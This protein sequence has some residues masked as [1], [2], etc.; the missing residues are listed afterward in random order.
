MLRAP[1]REFAVLFDLRAQD[2][3]DTAGYSRFDL[4]A[5]LGFQERIVGPFGD[6]SE[7]FENTDHRPIIERDVAMVTVAY[8]IKLRPP[9]SRVLRFKDMV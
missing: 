4:P 8:R 5:V 3:V 6:V 9:T 2:A 1:S 7:K